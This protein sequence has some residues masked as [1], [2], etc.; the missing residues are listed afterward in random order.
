ML[1]QQCSMFRVLPQPVCLAPSV[2][3]LPP[4][5]S[6]LI[7]PPPRIQMEEPKPRPRLPCWN[8]SSAHK[9]LTHHQTHPMVSLGLQPCPFMVPLSCVIWLLRLASLIS[10]Y[11]NILTIF[12]TCVCVWSRECQKLLVDIRDC[13]VR[14]PRFFLSTTQVSGLKLMLRGL[15]ESALGLFF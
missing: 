12:C 9:H 2:P 4:R 3:H 8:C 10:K 5:L 13:L 15:V 1:P 11:M 14:L 7:L 6:A